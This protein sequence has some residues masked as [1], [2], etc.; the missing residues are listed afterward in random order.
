MKI[1]QSD[2]KFHGVNSA[3]AY[4]ATT[5]WRIELCMAAFETKPPHCIA[6][7]SD[8]LLFVHRYCVQ[9]C[10]LGLV[11][12][13]KPVHA[14]GIDVDDSSHRSA[15]FVAARRCLA[16]TLSKAQ[17]TSTKHDAGWANGYAAVFPLPI[18][19]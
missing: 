18:R 17:R 19:L 6:A 11:D 1:G 3:P 14:L 15:K 8:V 9:P 5:A 10:G 4:A 7:A 16:D 2:F 12:Q 13:T